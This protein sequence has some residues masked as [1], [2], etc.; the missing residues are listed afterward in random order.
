MSR[1]LFIAFFI[2]MILLPL[3]GW[4]G[5]DEMKSSLLLQFSRLEEEYGG[6]LGLMAMN[7]K[8]RE[9]LAYHAEEKFPTASVIKL[10]I[11]AAFFNLVQ[12]GKIDPNLRLI[13][14]EKVKK[15]GSGIL[16]Q[17][18]E[19]TTITAGDAVK[20]MIMLSDNTATNLVLDQMGDTVDS[21]IGAVNRYAAGIGLKN[22]R[23]L[24]RV[25]SPETKQLAPEAIRYGFGVSTPE[26]MVK[27]LELMYS[28]SLV[29]AASS[30]SMVSIMKQQFY[31]DMI[32]RFLPARECDQVQVAHKTGFVQE[33]QSDVGIIYSPRVDIAM[34]IFVDKQSDH[35]EVIDNHG[36]LLGARAA[37]AV[38]DYFT[39]GTISPCDSG[40]QYDADWN[41]VPG[42]RW[43]IYRSAAAPF[44][45]PE[46]ELGF[47]S[48]DGTYY[49]KFP[50]YS[51][52]SV[53]VFVPDWFKEDP[54]GA[55]LLIHFH[56]HMNDNLGVLERYRMIESFLHERINAILIIPQG[57]YR[58]RDSFGGKMEDEKGLRRL[59][60]DVMSML[61]Q[62]KIVLTAR[63]SQLILSAHSGGYRPLAYSLE[64]GGMANQV[65]QVFIFDAL[66]AQ[67]DFF[68]KWLENGH[69]VMRGAFTDHLTKEHQ[70]F[71]ASLKESTRS[72]FIFGPSPVP[73]DEVVQNFLASWL[74][75]LP[76]D[77]HY[78]E[79]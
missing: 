70:D 74:H 50:H 69:G 34:A 65:S 11:M 43:G 75:E 41:R 17:L 20:L 78:N 45:H 39:S 76:E 31:A 19:G 30:Q 48:S 63:T 60:E 36:N 8:T 29:N 77:W 6:H 10:P 55:R 72:R 37:H 68:R 73:H 33:S 25:Y 40:P 7:L 58:A 67:Q 79:N 59:V 9:T 24:N 35:R 32:P 28:G 56:G 5:S 66:Y 1:G 44:P 26:D 3:P 13:L 62:D 27:L 64:K 46:R 21:Q 57:P 54:V 15:P 14:Q 52:N 12:A 2:C 18:S 61:V 49:P 22:T 53:I 4:S 51:D 47:T 23:L 42:G 71:A 16:Q 38:W